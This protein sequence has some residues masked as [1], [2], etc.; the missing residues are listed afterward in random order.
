MFKYIESIILYISPSDV[1]WNALTAFGTLISAS[2]VTIGGLFAY[3]QLKWAVRESRLKGILEMQKIIDSFSEE[4]KEIFSTFPADL[5]LKSE[6]FSTRPPSK[7]HTFTLSDEE[8]EKISLT[9]KQNKAYGELSEKQKKIALKVIGKLNDLAELIEDDFIDKKIFMGKY[10]LMVIR[11][12]YLLEP[13]RRKQDEDGN[14]GQRLLRLRKMAINYNSII[15]KHRS[16]AIIISVSG[17]KRVIIHG[18]E[19]ERNLIKKSIRYFKR[20]FLII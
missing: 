8:K 5:L 2:V 15:P 1:F 13:I 19:D 18:I 14:Y 17:E 9:G 11:L 20:K 6:Q 4:R 10:H 7:T 3:R 16:K 12:C